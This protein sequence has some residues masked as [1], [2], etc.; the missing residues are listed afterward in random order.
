MF[1]QPP[2]TFGV[3]IDG[4]PIENVEP[5]S[6]IHTG[7]TSKNQIPGNISWYEEHDARVSAGY[8]LHE[9]GSLSFEDRAMEVA[10]YRL[11][12]KVKMHTDDAIDREIKR[13]IK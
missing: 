1:R 5:T 13:K 7:I 8:N 12:Y 2:R 3:S 6:T 11:R 10:H 9:W 4:Y